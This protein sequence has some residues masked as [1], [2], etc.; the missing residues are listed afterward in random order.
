M[1]AWKKRKSIMR[2]ARFTVTFEPME[3][4]VLGDMASAVA[5]ALIHRA[6]SAP[7]DELA[8]LTGMASGHKEPPTDP[9]LAR[10]LPDFEMA[11]D[12]EYEGDNSLLR[13]LHENDICRAK[14]E[15]LAVITNALGPDG[16]VAVVA[17]E[18][19]AHAW[20]AGLN[21]IRLYLASGE[22]KGSEQEEQ[23]RD[24]LVQWLAFNQESLLEAMMG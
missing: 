24:M 17:T 20:V 19:E 1:E 22:L 5:E 6:Q 18:E 15:N 3:R 11:G 12:E 14:L 13:S 8:E 7:K 16:N 2:G 9:A 4:E 21:D 23:D 10:L